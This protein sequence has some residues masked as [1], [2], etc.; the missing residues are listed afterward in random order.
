MNP[1]ERE[2]GIRNP[3]PWI[4]MGAV[5]APILILLWSYLQSSP[6]MRDRIIVLFAPVAGAVGGW[7]FYALNPW[8]KANGWRK[9]IILMIAILVYLM[10]LILGFT[11]ARLGVF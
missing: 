7:V 5:L 6:G 10:A 8:G 11:V 1:T 9:T 4:L 2:A 3:L